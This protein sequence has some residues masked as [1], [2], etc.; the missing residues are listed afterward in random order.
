MDQPKTPNKAIIGIIVVVLLV[1]AATAVVIISSNSAT[2]ETTD[3]AVSSSPEASTSVSPS[4]S[5]STAATNG[6]KN[7]TYNATGSYQT[8]GGQESI[9]VNVTLTDGIITDA[10]VTQQGKTGEAQ[11]Y[12]SKF[13]SGYKS[14]VVGKK[15]SEVNLSRVAGSSLTPIGFNDAISDIEKQATA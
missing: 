11:E 9:S 12:Q 13:V 1:A 3:T 2:K 4:A 10:T 8:P 15:I 5:A 7:G 14:Q 6:F